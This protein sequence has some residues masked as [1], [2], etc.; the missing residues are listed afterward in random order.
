MFARLLKEA[1]LTG[2]EY[3]VPREA[4]DAYENAIGTARAARRIPAQAHSARVG[5]REARKAT[6]TARRVYRL[7][8]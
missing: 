8:R 7:F 5:V 3:V 1:V 2:V 6:A 4:R